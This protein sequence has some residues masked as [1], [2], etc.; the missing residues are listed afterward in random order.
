MLVSRKFSA[1]EYRQRVKLFYQL[2]EFKFL[3]KSLWD[4][5]G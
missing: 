5:I 2:A 1:E 3:P 4:S